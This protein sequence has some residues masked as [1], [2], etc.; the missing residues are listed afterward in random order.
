MLRKLSIFS[1]YAFFLAIMLLVSVLI[2]TMLPFVQYGVRIV[3]SGS[4]LPTF[5]TGSVILIS[6]VDSYTV[7]DIITFK[8]LVDSEV[9][10]HRIVE[11]RIVAGE[12]EYVTKGDANNVEDM[13]PVKR[14]EVFGKV[15]GHVPYVGYLLSFFRQPVGFLL[16]VVVPAALVVVEQVE[17]IKREMHQQKQTE[18]D[19]HMTHV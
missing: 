17:K 13:D 16:L 18:Q 15:R 5:S 7:G 3:E 12:E 6:P 14:A 19:E 8:R 10:T 1:G 4:M 11:E 9:T 2:G